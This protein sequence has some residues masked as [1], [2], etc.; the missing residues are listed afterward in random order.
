MVKV[1][2]GAGVWTQ[3]PSGTTNYNAVANATGK[4]VFNE[5]K[6]SSAYVWAFIKHPIPIIPNL[7]LEYTT[8]SERGVATGTWEGVDVGSSKS[9]FDVK[10][11]DIIPYYNILDNTFWITLDVGFGVKIIDVDYAIAPTTGFNGYSYAK[12]VPVPMAYLRTRAEMP[13]TNLALEADV[14]YIAYNDSKF[15]DARVKVDYTF[16]I[17]PLIQPALEIGYRTQKLEINEKSIDIR[18][19]VDFSGPYAGLM[20]RF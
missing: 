8:F 2:M 19:D 5:D 1:E 16:D 15:Y 9:V 17:F 12:Y 4:D 3:T 14:K 18:T 10:Q 20:I 11:Y 7:R 13:I 6:D